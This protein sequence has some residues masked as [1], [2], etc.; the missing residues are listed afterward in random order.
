MA[1]HLT[2]TKTANPPP[3]GGSLIHRRQERGLLAGLTLLICALRGMRETQRHPLYQQ[4]A[5]ARSAIA[6]P[7]LL[8]LFTC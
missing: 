1:F 4:R 2:N 5:I 7:A 8:V 6:A 3:V